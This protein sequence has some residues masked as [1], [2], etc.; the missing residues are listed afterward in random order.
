MTSRIKVKHLTDYST[1]DSSKKV[2]KWI[3][4]ELNDRSIQKNRDDQE[5]N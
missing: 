3:P 4:S 2:D 1:V 5:I